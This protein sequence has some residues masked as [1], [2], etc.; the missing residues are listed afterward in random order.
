MSSEDEAATVSRH[1]GTKGV[2]TSREKGQE[3]LLD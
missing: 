1:R 2:M 3:G